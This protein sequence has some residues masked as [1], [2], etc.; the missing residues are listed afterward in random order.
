MDIP[1]VVEYKHQVHVRR[2]VTVCKNSEVDKCAPV[3]AALNSEQLPKP[4]EMSAND[5]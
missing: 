1:P 5:Q 4:S 3:E 2:L